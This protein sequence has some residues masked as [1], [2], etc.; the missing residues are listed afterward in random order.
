M[1]DESQGYNLLSGAL[2]HYRAE[3]IANSEPVMRVQLMKDKIVAL[4]QFYQNNTIKYQDSPE[5][6][7]V[8]YRYL[9]PLNVSY[10]W[11]LQNLSSYY[12]DIGFVW[13]FAFMMLICGIKYA[14]ARRH[15]EL[16]VIGL[17]GLVGRLIWWIIGGAILWYGIGQIVWLILSVVLFVQYLASEQ[18]DTSDSYLLYVT[19][20]ILAMW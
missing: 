7:F 17:T 2:V 3:N 14:I 16:L 5:K 8:P 13:L 12:T 18:E 9:I 4:R 15:Q 1:S 10:N 20:A 6:I 11:S 19:L